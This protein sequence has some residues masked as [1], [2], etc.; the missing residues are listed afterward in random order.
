MLQEIGLTIDGLFGDVPEELRC[1]GLKLPEGMG[2]QEVR[3]RL[4]DIAAKN[5]INLTSFLGGGFYD[6]FIPSVV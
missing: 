6:H 1:K 2:E 4:A 3:N 5:Y